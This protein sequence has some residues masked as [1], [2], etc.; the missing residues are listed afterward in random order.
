MAKDIEKD[1]AGGGTHTVSVYVGD[2][3]WQ[4]VL[5]TRDLAYA[6]AFYD[7]IEGRKRLLTVDD[8]KPKKKG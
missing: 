2:G 8:P 4:P 5:T 7:D 6:Q 3:L 1:H